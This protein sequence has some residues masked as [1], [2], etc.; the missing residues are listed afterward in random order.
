MLSETEKAHA[1][2]K[3]ELGVARKKQK[4]ASAR[5]QKARAAFR[6]KANPANR[7]KVDDLVAQVKGLAEALA[8]IAKAAYDAAE[9][10]M[11]MK[12]DAMLEER[13]AK[14]SCSARLMPYSRA[15]FSAV[16]PIIMPV[17]GSVRPN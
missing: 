5:L 6:A 13:K 3:R 9:K 2:A 7:K 10:L 17:V 15:N 1:K 16:L 11:P 4:A 8:D 12:A 14:A